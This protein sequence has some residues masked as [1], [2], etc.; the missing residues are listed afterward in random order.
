MM[1]R[2]YYDPND[3]TKAF[4]N[5]CSLNTRNKRK[6]TGYTFWNLYSLSLEESDTHANIK[7]HIH[8]GLHAMGLSD[9][10]AD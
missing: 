6:I 8:E 9:D 4:A 3:G 7:T 2:T 10:L 1:I 5:Y